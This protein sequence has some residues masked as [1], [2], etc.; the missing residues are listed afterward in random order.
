MDPTKIVRFRVNEEVGA[1]QRLIETVSRSEQKSV[2]SELNR[3]FITIGRD[4]SDGKYCHRSPGVR[5]PRRLAPYHSK[6]AHALLHRSS[7][8]EI[9]RAGD[10]PQPIGDNPAKVENRDAA[11]QMSRRSPRLIHL[12]P[13]RCVRDVKLKSLF[14]HFQPK[15]KIVL[16]RNFRRVRDNATVCQGRFLLPRCGGQRFT[17]H[18]EQ[19][20]YLLPVSTAA[21]LLSQAYFRPSR[22]LN[23]RAALARLGGRA[24]LA[25]SFKQMTL[26]NCTCS[27]DIP[28]SASL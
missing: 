23:R 12:E 11:Y 27:V 24:E 17:S 19:K 6:E 3:P 18:Q 14:V 7:W 1:Q 5:G 21:N 25:T 10:G 15:R 28:I 9:I 4:V 20:M 2:L 26:Q 13:A 22:T 16:R 8:H